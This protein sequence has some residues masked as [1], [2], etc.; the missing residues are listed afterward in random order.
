MPQYRVVYDHAPVYTIDNSGDHTRLRVNGY[1]AIGTILTDLTGESENFS[2]VPYM[3]FEG[4]M[5]CIAAFAVVLEGGPPAPPPEPLPPPSP[6]PPDPVIPPAP[7]PSISQPYYHHV[8][9][10]ALVF[11]EPNRSA[12]ILG[13]FPSDPGWRNPVQ[14]SAGLPLSS[15]DRMWRQVLNCADKK[16][17]GGWVVEGEPGYNVRYF[18]QPPQ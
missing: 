15:D 12:A 3:L 2:G 5:T 17:I 14:L 7:E 18:Y 11:S 8:A 6:P 10:S 1:K 9:T 13:T 4:G 16:L